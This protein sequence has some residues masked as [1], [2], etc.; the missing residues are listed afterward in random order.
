M[1]TSQFDM[2]A[3]SINHHNYGIDLLRMLSMYMVCML[4]TLGR[5]GI[6]TG[7][8]SDPVK[9]HIAWFFEIAAYCSINCFAMIS[10]YVGV[11]SRFK[12]R[13]LLRLWLQ[14][15]F[16]TIGITLIFLVF[17]P[18]SVNAKDIIISLLPI[19]S[20]TYWYLSAYTLMFFLIPQMNF[21]LEKQEKRI[22]KTFIWTFFILFSLCSLPIGIRGI[23]SPVKSGYSAIWLA[24]LYMIGGFIRIHGI[25]ALFIFSSNNPK[26]KSLTN[27]IDTLLGNQLGRLSIYMVCILVTYFIYTCGPHIT[28][29]IINRKI[30]FFSFVDYTSP[31]ILL[32]AIALLELFSHLSLASCSAL[33]RLTSPL[34][35]GVY[36]IHC[37]RLFYRLVFEGAFVK[38]SE[39]P[40]IILPFAIIIIPLIIYILCSLIDFVRLKLFQF[41]KIA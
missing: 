36:L 21:I 23:A 24:Y 11:K 13:N 41:L 33:I 1:S 38:V 16:Y 40:T 37:Q 2:S 35:F 26:S 3:P 14:T 28:K 39:F 5:G 4:H 34:A 6:I 22:L 31:T 17:R 32:A 8:T 27:C 30:S 10:G 9:Y 20:G 7:T 12:Y 15:L 18:S 19:S 29:M 25:T